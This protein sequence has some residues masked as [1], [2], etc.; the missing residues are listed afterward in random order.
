MHS[1]IGID[2]AA[3]IRTFLGQ[4]RSATDLD[5]NNTTGLLLAALI[6]AG[7]DRLVLPGDGHILLRW[8][9]LAAVAAHDLSLTKLYEGHTDA[10]AIL[11]EAGTT[12]PALNSR[13]GV[14]CAEPPQAR[15]E[16]RQAG[17]EGGQEVRL[18]GV[19]AWCS[20]ARVLTHAILS[21][22]DEQGQPGLVAVDLYQPGIVISDEGWHAVGMANTMSVNVR[23]NEAEG[24]AVGS[25]GF[26]TRRPGFWHGAA[27]IAA[28]WYGA[29]AQLVHYLREHL[30][31]R[32]D[33]HA[34][35]HLGRADMA[36]HMAA[37][38]LRAAAQE[39]DAAPLDDSYRSAMRARLGCEWGATQVM[40]ALGQA[41]GAAPY[42]RDPWSSRMLADLPVFLRQSHAERDLAAL[43]R[44]CIEQG[45]IEREHPWQL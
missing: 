36:L 43:G 8:Q 30:S 10:L 42:C 33:P 40:Q 1:A 23:F 15:V 37:C 13:W 34:M 32:N 18:N 22:W 17:G 26:Y 20:G 31:T 38:A 7:L 11:A 44:F 14:W 2:Q 16:I 39:I 4:R 24:V 29:A 35:A 21:G 25:P 27:G 41:L 5:V 28:C 6:E 45:A 12:P 9:A 19:K 3:A